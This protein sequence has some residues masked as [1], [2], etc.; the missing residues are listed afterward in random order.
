MIIFRKCKTHVKFCLFKFKKITEGPGIGQQGTGCVLTDLYVRR[1]DHSPWY[2]GD[3]GTA[4]PGEPLSSE[5][6]G[7]A[8]QAQIRVTQSLCASVSPS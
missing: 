5:V 1:A 3:V 2:D 6:T 8:V 7:Q 4:V